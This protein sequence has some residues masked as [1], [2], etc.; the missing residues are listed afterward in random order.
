[1]TEKQLNK[2]K[3]GYAFAITNGNVELKS[4]QVYGVKWEVK[5]SLVYEPFVAL[6]HVG[7]IGIYKA[8]SD[9]RECFFVIRNYQPVEKT[10]EREFIIEEQAN[11]VRQL[12]INLLN[13]DN[14]PVYSALARF[15]AQRDEF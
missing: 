8:E 12:S 9:G 1:M 3:G 7:N 6:G 14:L 10:R 15:F 4:F 11:S 2:T 13:K 5:E